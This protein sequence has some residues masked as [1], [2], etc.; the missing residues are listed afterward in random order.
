MVELRISQ[1][2]LDKVREDTKMKISELEKATA[3]FYVPKTAQGM[4]VA[5]NSANGV[6]EQNQ[7]R[8]NSMRWER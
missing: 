5:Q 7:Q 4:T 2:I 6:E 3:V 1:L 8:S